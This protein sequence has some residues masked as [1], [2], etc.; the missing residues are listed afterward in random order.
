[1]PNVSAFDAFVNGK[2]IEQERGG[3]EVKRK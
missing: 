3:R 1:M 2:K